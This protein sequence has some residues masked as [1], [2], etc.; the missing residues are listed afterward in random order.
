MRLSAAL[1]GLSAGVLHGFA[2]PSR[3]LVWI[4]AS[5]G[6]ACAAARRPPACALLGVLLL[7]FAGGALD[8]VAR[9]PRGPLDELARDVPRC[10]WRAAALEQEGALGTLVAVESIDC[11]GDDRYLDPGLAFIR[12]QPDA[13]SR[14]EGE[15]WLVPL[16]DDGFAVARRRFGAAAEISASLLRV[17]PPPPGPLA[18]AA[19]LRAGLAHAVGDLSPDRAGLLTGVT[20]GDTDE[21]AADV[22]EDFRRSGLSH[23]V[24]VS[25]ENV[26]MV[27]GAL[28]FVTRRVPIRMRAVLALVVLG[29]FVL[30][31]GPQPSVLR[32]AAMAVVAIAALAYGLRPEPWHALTLAL[33]AVIA[34]R[35]QI[36]FAAGLHL[37]AAATAGILLWARPLAR[38]LP[39]PSWAA[40]GLAVTLSAQLATAPLIAGLFGQLSVTG[41]IANLIALPAVPP[42]TVLGLC[43]AIAGAV[44]PGLGAAVAHLAEP[45]VAWVLFVARVFGRPSWAALPVPSSSAWLLG[46]LALGAAIAAASRARRSD[47]R[48]G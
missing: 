34:L 5:S 2:G 19:I 20:T 38:R 32:A 23:V 11:G 17:R 9:S 40:A 47:V 33:V 3:A 45:F 43:A 21:L 1:V 27:L 26:V 4:A 44:S 18:V 41:P 46:A 36:L 28:A 14:V 30:I 48:V 8:A 15:G 25:G 10:R 29:L 16:G 12:Q 31:V 35:P 6:V 39:L 22:V 24:A 37:S 7:A 42:A 13:G